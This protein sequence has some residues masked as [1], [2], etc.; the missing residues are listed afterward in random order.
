M[1]WVE[2]CTCEEPTVGVRV[3]QLQQYRSGVS[4]ADLKEGATC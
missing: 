1:L 4:T 2:H 3:Q